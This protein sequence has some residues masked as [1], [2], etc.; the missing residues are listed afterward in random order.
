MPTKAFVSARLSYLLSSEEKP[1]QY[2]FPPPNGMPWEN[3]HY[4]WRDVHVADARYHA[5]G[6]SVDREGFELWDAPSALRDFADPDVVTR[7]YY[8][9]LAE[10]ACQVTGARHAYVFDHLVRKREAGRGTLDFGRSVKGGSATANGRIHN[11]Y[12]EQSGMQRLQRVLGEHAAPARHGRY[13][14]VN[15]WRSISGPVLDT[16]LAVCDARSIA[17][18]DLVP[19]DVHYPRR[20][21]EIYLLR[22]APRHGWSYFSRMDRH[23]ALVFKQYDSQASGV[24]RY[25]PHTAFD[26]PEVPA[27]APLRESI[28]ARCLVI[29]D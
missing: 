26:L 29:Y 3:S 15:V 18:S 21:G 24:A 10:L 8:P 28:E 11:D 17:A 20:T 22:Y 9:E 23:E 5:D 13:S 19:A 14:I 16:P 2:A 1:Y 7:S 25:T 4:E 12:T 27:D 6:I